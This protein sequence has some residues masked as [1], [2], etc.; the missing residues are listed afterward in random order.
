MEPRQLEKE[1]SFQTFPALFRLFVH[2]DLPKDT[3]MMG[4]AR[5]NMTQEEFHERISGHFKGTDE[6]KQAFLQRC[7]YMAGQYDDDEAFAKLNDALTKWEDERGGG[8]RNRVFYFAL[9][10]NVFVPVSHHLRKTCYAD[11]GINRVVVEKPFGKDLETCSHMLKEMQSMWTE[12]ETFRIDHYLGKEMVKNIIPL[13]FGNPVVEHTLN[14]YMVD[15]VQI[16]FKE[17]FGTEGRGGYFDDFGIIRDIQQNHLCQVFSLI[18]MEEPESFTPE[19]IRDAKVNLLRSVKPI[20]A[21]DVLLGQY[22]AHNG[23]PGYKDDETVPKDSNTP[24]FAAVV[25]H[26][27]NDRW[28]DV[29][30]IMKAGKA[31]D[32]SKVEIRVQYR[33]LEHDIHNIERNELVIRIQPGEALYFIMN[34]KVPG[35]ASETVPVE[36]D[37]TYKHR[38]QDAYI[39]EAYEALILDC[40]RD[41]HSNFVRD[42]ELEASWSIFTPI[43]HA[44]DAGE[45]PCE[46]YKYGSRGP[47]QLNDFIE[48]FGY[49]PKKNYEWPETNVKELCSKE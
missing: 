3:L 39:P 1:T 27:D 8:Q 20:S 45:L 49:K 21:D 7:R 40:L 24:T 14:K 5:S 11:D 10:P 13:R 35:H 22:V 48:K 2:G 47:E 17:P 18:A 42:D 34:T 16:T 37:L 23:K 46:P 12:A 36:L 6:Q 25:L 9:P 32:E 28:R 38:F 15:N 33:D 31:L 29:P 30:F 19:A 41:E 44:I 43:L 26:V 4:Y